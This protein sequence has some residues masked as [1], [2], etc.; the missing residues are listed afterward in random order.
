L[1]L[2]GWFYFSIAFLLLLALP[3]LVAHAEDPLQHKSWGIAQVEAEKAWKITSGSRSV[4]VAV[5][6]TGVD[7]DHPDLASNIWTNSGESGV[8]SQGRRK[9][10]N[11]IDDDHNGFVDDV[12]GWNFVEDN[13]DVSDHHGH[14]THVSGIIGARA[15]NGIGTAGV[16]SRVSIMALKY[17][18]PGRKESDNLVNTIRAIRYATQMNANIINYSGGGFSAS[19]TEEEAIRQAGLKSIVVVAAAGN[20]RINSDI[21]GFYPADYGLPNVISVTAVDKQRK[22]LTSSNYGRQTVHIAAPGKEIFST[23]PHGRYGVMTGTSQA[24]AFVSGALALLFSDPKQ[25]RDPVALIQNLALT[26]DYERSLTGKTRFEN[27]LNVS[28][29]LTMK[30][31]E[32]AAN[33][34]AQVGSEVDESFNF[35]SEVPL[36]VLRTRLNRAPSAA[37]GQATFRISDSGDK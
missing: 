15:G 20:E 31:V 19:P 30:G 16:A 24:T 22:F 1:S 13:N 32:F 17:Y 36:G 27:T 2:V 18:D 26:G 3:S 29:M 10:T 21:F 28:R 12:H 33:N 23:L 8:D 6:D 25:T 34:R 14:G 11:G 4:V 7:I 35:S 9:E 5:I 37:T